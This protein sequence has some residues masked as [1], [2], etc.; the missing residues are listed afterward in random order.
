MEILQYQSK[1]EAVAAAGENLNS[2]LVENK[3]QAVLLMLSAGSALAILDY[4]G[5]LALSENLTVSMI[6]ERFSQEKDINNFLQMQKT[7]FYTRA[8]AK[9]ISF[10]GTLPRPQESMPDFA[11]RWEK[12]LHNWQEKNPKGIVIATLGMGSDG[13][14]AGI[15]PED[16]EKKFKKLFNSS[17]WTAGYDVG[18]K[19]K[20]KE[21]VTTTLTFFKQIDH[22]IS[23]ICGEEKKQ[24]F[25]ELLN[26]R[27][28]SNILPAVAIANLKSVKVFTDIR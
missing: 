21:R 19:N 6:D 2:L 8:M 24:K 12:S 5:E 28:P 18:N 15:F 26:S 7:D 23:Y 3:K 9:D 11:A 22:G 13:H 16:D 4:V 27:Q 20:Y 14:V 1:D 10:I 25:Y 17:S